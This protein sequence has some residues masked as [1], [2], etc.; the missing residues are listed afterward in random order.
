MEELSKLERRRL[1]KQRRKEE[2]K[3]EKSQKNKKSLKKNLIIGLL[4]VI[5]VFASIYFFSWLNKQPG[6]YD[7]FAKC[8]TEKGFIVAGTD[9]CPSCQTQKEY[10]SRKSFE[11]I[12]Y[13][14]CDENKLWCTANG[15][16]G[17]PT[18]ILP[19]QNKLPG[20]KKISEL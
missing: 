6:K 18:W 20:V 14:N 2:K 8:L 19:D 1:N 15:I 5:I 11:Y 16:T 9:W 12:N 10:F 7:D 17:Y 13:K 4:I 3:Q